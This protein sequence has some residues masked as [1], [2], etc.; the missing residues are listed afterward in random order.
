MKENILYLECGS[1][2]S[3]D[4]TVA[5]LLDLG[6]DR[7]VLKEALKSIPIRGFRV[8]ISRV[9]KAGLDVCDFHV[10]LDEEHENH[11]HDMEYLF[12]DG[13]GGERRYGERGPHGEERPCGDGL[14]SA[15][16]SC[17]ER[18]LYGKDGHH[19]GGRGH[20]HAHG[21]RG[22]PEILHIIEHTDMTERAR[23]TA[24]RIFRI[25][26][27]AEAKAHGVS[28]SEVHFHEV[29]A[30]D[31]IV[32]IISVAV[33]LDD[34]R[35]KE[36]IVPVLCEGTGTVRCQ[37]GILNVPVPAVLNIVQE[38]Q[39]ELSITDIRGEMVTPTGAAIVAAVRTSDKLPGRFRVV[40]D[41]KSVV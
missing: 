25:L 41:R 36:C 18:S 22:M 2:I 31:S 23:E 16:H 3:G 32:D 39:L 27:T 30:V 35:V 28:E 38:H 6:A 34:L 17:G 24:K 8:K 26:A 12:G 14:H 21:H 5:A 20:A 4:M 19:H 9:K 37:H 1:G 11:D 13:H 10:I 40:R 15:E 7:K 33:C 29:G